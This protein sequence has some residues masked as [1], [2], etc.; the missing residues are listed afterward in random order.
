LSDRASAPPIDAEDAT[1]TDHPD[2]TFLWTTYARNPL[3]LGYS[4]FLDDNR[5]V[6]LLTRCLGRA[7]EIL[8]L[9]LRS[10]EDGRSP[11]PL[12]R[13][14]LLQAIIAGLAALPLSD[15]NRARYL[16]YH[17]DGLMRYLRR[18]KTQTLELSAVEDGPT[19]MARA[20]LRFDGEI[21]RLG[22]ELD[23]WSESLHKQWHTRTNLSWDGDFAAWGQALRDLFEYINP[24]CATL[25][26]RLDPFAEL[27]VFPL[28][29]KVFHGLANQ[30]GLSHLNEAFLH[31]LLAG[32][33]PEG[34]DCQR[35]VQLVPNL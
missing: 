35:P 17:R 4:P 13:R 34:Q 21:E 3:S 16:L 6:Y 20:L 19:I 10:D 14:L 11:F 31:H 33:T 15:S 7:T 18:R 8:I 29:F 12:Q 24:Q 23:G 1:S 22:T 27:P 9:R 5:Y 30:I 28:L 2:R 32:L 25:C 26:Q